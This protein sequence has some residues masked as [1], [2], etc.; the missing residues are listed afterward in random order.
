MAQEPAENTYVTELVKAISDVGRG[1]G[2]DAEAF[3]RTGAGYLDVV[4][5]RDGEVV[6]IIEVKRPEISLSDPQLLEQ[7]MRYAE[8]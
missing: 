1:L 4:L 3:L 6:A 8:W 2:F 7:A 5:K